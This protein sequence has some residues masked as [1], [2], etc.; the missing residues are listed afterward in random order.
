[1][2]GRLSTTIRAGLI[3]AGI[4]G[5]FTAGAVPGAYFLGRAHKS[6]AIARADAN[7]M[8]E[9]FREET[10]RLAGV[11]TTAET[12]LDEDRV[13]R[14]QHVAD[15]LADARQLAADAAAARRAF[16]ESQDRS[17]P[18]ADDDVRVFNQ[19][20]GLTAEPGPANP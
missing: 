11:A 18:A 7:Q 12:R 1:M 4:M 19:A 3:G 2:I 13:W 15:F 6:A 10:E 8:R 5:A 17:C 9:A 14:S 16:H 20:F